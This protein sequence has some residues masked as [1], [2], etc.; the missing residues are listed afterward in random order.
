MQRC[1]PYR[2]RPSKIEASRQGTTKQFI[3]DPVYIIEIFFLERSVWTLVG[4]NTSKLVHAIHPIQIVLF[5]LLSRL[6]NIKY[7]LKMRPIVGLFHNLHEI[8]EVDVR[9][10]RGSFSYW[11]HL[12]FFV[13]ILFNFGVF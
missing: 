11:F 3:F 5:T 4:G 7:V 10:S 9:F 1:K 12:L 6:R 13:G 8:D 2:F